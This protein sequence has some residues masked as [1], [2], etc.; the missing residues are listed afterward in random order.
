[1]VPWSNP[2]A[3]H[4]GG[5]QIAS[6]GLSSRLSLIT[7]ICLVMYPSFCQKVT[8]LLGVKLQ[9]PIIFGEVD[10]LTRG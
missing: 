4:A 10:P 1:M 9:L 2:T 8:S 3:A 5:N 7:V 6:R